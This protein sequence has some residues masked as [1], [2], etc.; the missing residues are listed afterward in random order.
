MNIRKSVAFLH[1]KNEQSG[2]KT[3]KTIQFTIASKE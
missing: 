2:G 1:T 3:D